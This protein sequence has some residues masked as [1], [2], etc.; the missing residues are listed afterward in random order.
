MT[1]LPA[2]L[3]AEADRALA[4]SRY[5]DAE[6]RVRQALA[7]LPIERVNEVAIEA[8]MLADDLEKDLHFATQPSPAVDPFDGHKV[9]DLVEV[10]PNANGGWMRGRIVALVPASLGGRP[11]L[12][13]D[14]GHGL[15][16]RRNVGE[17]WLRRPA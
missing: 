3:R 14:V 13:I 11:V 16:W 8:E 15:P 5:Q 2:N 17:A 7:K 1:D 6:H 4:M 12:E 9:S 10:Y